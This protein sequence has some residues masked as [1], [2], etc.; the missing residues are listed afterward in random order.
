M[1]AVL[2]TLLLLL[3]PALALAATDVQGVLP[4]ETV[5]KRSG[6]P[7]VLHGDVTVPWGVKLTVEPGVQVIAATDDALGSGVDPRRVEL[8]VDGTLLVRGT[9]E[10]P[11]EFTS[12]GAE[13]AWYGIRVRGGRGTVIDG[14]TLSRAS[15]GIS[16][17]MSAA[18]RNTAVSAQAQDCLQ[19]TWGTPSLRGND[20]SGC[21]G[22]PQRLP[23]PTPVLERPSPPVVVPSRL[24]APRPL[25]ERPVPERPVP[26]R[27]AVQ[28]VPAALPPPRLPSPAPVATPV[29]LVTETPTPSRPLP[30][31]LGAPP[32]TGAPASGECALQPQVDEPPECPGVRRWRKNQERVGEVSP[33]SALPAPPGPS[34]LAA[35]VHPPRPLASGPPPPTVEP[36]RGRASSLAGLETSRRWPGAPPATARA[37]A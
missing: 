30:T 3:L 23:E 20:L 21:G 36:P 28:P 13:G 4:G 34:P 25:L 33:G 6:S 14:A 37:G 5:W 2:L 31:R 35:C 15:Q 24:P 10:L 7:Y 19:V 1:R 22:R 26:E 27:L 29:K 8:I 11:V 16:L 32:G 17:G 12:Q 18:V 9:A